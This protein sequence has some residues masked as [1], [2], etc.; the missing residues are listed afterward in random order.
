MRDVR[1]ATSYTLDELLADLTEV[2][3]RSP[4]YGAFTHARISILT[5]GTVLEAA[6]GF[7]IDEVR[8]DGAIR[9]LE[10]VTYAIE[11]EENRDTLEILDDEIARAARRTAEVTG[12]DE[13]WLAGDV[14]RIVEALVDTIV[15]LRT[16]LATLD[17]LCDCAAAETDDG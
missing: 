15:D 2:A 7:E 17:E 5:P 1:T 6:E 12:R 11:A 16:E 3:G 4:L 10:L 14:D 13:S 8:A 9:S